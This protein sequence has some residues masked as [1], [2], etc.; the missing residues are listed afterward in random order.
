MTALGISSYKGNLKI[1][2]MLYTAG[3]DINLANKQGISPL[4]LAIK[5]NNMQCIK[6]LIERKAKVH[7][8]DVI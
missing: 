3:A 6:Y 5:S 2:E 4:Y 1:L 7:F 8:Q